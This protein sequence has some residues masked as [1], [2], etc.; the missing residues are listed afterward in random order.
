MK[1]TEK[2]MKMNVKLTTTGDGVYN[3]HKKIQIKLIIH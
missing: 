2:I 1:L 3:N